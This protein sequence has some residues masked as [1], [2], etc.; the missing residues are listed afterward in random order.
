MDKNKLVNVI[1]NIPYITRTETLN[2][3][4]SFIGEQS[5]KYELEEGNT[6]TIGLDTQTVFYQRSKFYTGQNIQILSFKGINIYTSLFIIPS[7]KI[8]LLKFNW[9]GEMVRH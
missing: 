9:G 8:Q 2:G 6:I 5:E 4:G 1:G 3:I 7:L